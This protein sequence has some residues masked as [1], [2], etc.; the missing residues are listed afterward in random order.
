MSDSSLEVHDDEVGKEACDR[1]LSRAA[2]SLLEA[3]LR[4]SVFL[5]DPMIHATDDDI[6]TI[7]E[8][9]LRDARPAECPLFPSRDILRHDEEQSISIKPPSNSLKGAYPS[10]TLAERRKAS[11]KRPKRWW[12]CGIC[13]KVFSSRYYMDL[14]LKT[15]HNPDRRVINAAVEGT[16]TGT[17]T[18]SSVLVCPADEWCRMLGE[19]NC[20]QQA[21]LD[22]PFYDRGSDGWSDDG[23]FIQHKYSKLAHSIPCDVGPI[24]AQCRNI[25]DS[26]R[27]ED[28]SICD[29][30][31]C[32]AH[33]HYLWEG[34]DSSSMIPQD[35]RSIWMYETQHH[36]NGTLL[37]I[38][39]CVLICVWVYYV[40][41]IGP[42]T[43]PKQSKK[44]MLDP[45]KRLLQKS[46]GATT[47]TSKSAG[48]R[49]TT[50]MLH[51]PRH[52]L[53]TSTTAACKFE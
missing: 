12:K 44:N 16:S 25:L 37:G 5:G 22:E 24:R 1:R 14:H 46:P 13:S 48:T 6:W 2:R 10:L 43:P 11:P 3:T 28:K 39:I 4:Q 35:W 33:H 53:D 8:R 17:A 38:F 30:L 7:L 21:L 51:H 15:H 49:T 45:G 34:A 50:G 47:T 29:Y 41:V 23:Q 32:P 52:H 20:H 27:M 36:S 40:A 31:V 9:W 42:F 18:S 19:A 26:C